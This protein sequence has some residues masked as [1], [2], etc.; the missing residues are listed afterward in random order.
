MVVTGVS[1]VTVKIQTKYGYQQ[2]G[3]D[4]ELVVQ[5]PDSLMT[6]QICGFYSSVLVCWVVK[7]W[8]SICTKG[9]SLVTSVTS[10]IALCFETE[11]LIGPRFAN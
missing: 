8:M 4:T 11:S 2:G 6:P 1:K 3:M 5:F 9:K 7:V 10:S